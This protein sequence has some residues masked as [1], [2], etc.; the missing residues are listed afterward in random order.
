MAALYC[1]IFIALFVTV[2]GVIADIINAF[3]W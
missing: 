3:I 2:G 1:I